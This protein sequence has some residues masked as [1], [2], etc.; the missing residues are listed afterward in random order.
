MQAHMVSVSGR[1]VTSVYKKGRPAALITPVAKPSNT[2][3]CLR[4]YT[5]FVSVNVCATKRTLPVLNE[6]W[7]C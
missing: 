3:N 1:L 5:C 7:L 6:K 4:P 2:Q